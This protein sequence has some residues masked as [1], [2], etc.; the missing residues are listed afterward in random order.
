M[1]SRPHVRPQG[2]ASGRKNR[3]GTWVWE[4][5]SWSECWCGM[6]HSNRMIPRRF[7]IRSWDSPKSKNVAG[8]LLY[9]ENLSGKRQYFLIQ[10]YNNLFGFP[11]GGM[12]KNDGSY[13]QAAL[14]EFYEETGTMLPM[15]EKQFLEIR[16]TFGENRVS[17]FM[18]KVNP[19]F[20]ILTRPISDVEINSFGFVD[21]DNLGNFRLTKMTTG[22]L[23][24]IKKYK[25]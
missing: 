4:K 22:I 18:A 25:K 9:K 12:E 23:D 14:R 15:E 24:Y 20:Q 1:A 10:C 6:H 21:E 17:I 5:A 3:D 2:I 19:A 13:F 11:K 8:V 16:K 7:W